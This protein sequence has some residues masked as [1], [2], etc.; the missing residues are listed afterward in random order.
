MVIAEVTFNCTGTAGHGSLLL[1]NTCGEKI[2]Y[3]LNK[4]TEFRSSE[5]K[6]LED[7]P[8]LT[9][10]D[11]TTVNLTMIKGGVQSNVVPSAMSITFDVRIAIDRSQV[12][13]EAMVFAREEEKNDSRKN[14]CKL[15]LFP[16]EP[17]VR[18]SWWRYRLG[19]RTK[20]ITCPGNKNRC[21]KQILGCI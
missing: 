1:K 14:F 9:I 11:V 7:N 13:F 4:M 15:K 18:R 6:K 8:D 10:G 3:I 20:G 2:N 21:V 19:F 12:E 5:A 17:F 16:V